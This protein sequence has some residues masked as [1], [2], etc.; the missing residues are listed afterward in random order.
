M[1]LDEDRIE[2]KQLLSPIQSSQFIALSIDV[3]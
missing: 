3:V 1:N 2:A